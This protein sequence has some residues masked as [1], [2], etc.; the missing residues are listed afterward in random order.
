[1][2]SP[3]SSNDPTDAESA[4]KLIGAILLRGRL[5]ALG[6]ALVWRMATAGEKRTLA[7]AGFGP[8]PV[9]LPD[10]EDLVEELILE[11]IDPAPAEE[12]LGL[13]DLHVILDGLQPDDDGYRL[14]E[15]MR[16]RLVAASRCSPRA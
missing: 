2:P 4:K 5:R 1:M 13:G 9:S 6:L 3:T 12:P 10:V 7:R 11:S 14:L 15:A 16:E 8:E